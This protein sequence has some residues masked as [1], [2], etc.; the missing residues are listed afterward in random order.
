MLGSFSGPRTPSSSRRVSLPSAFCSMPAKTLTQLGITHIPRCDSHREVCYGGRSLSTDEHVI[1]RAYGEPH[2]HHLEHF[3]EIHDLGRFGDFKYK[4]WI[5]IFEGFLKQIGPECRAIL[6]SSFPIRF[7]VGRV[8]LQ[9]SARTLKPLWE[10]FDSIPSLFDPEAK[11]KCVAGIEICWA[12]ER[13]STFG[14]HPIDL[15]LPLSSQ[16]MRTIANTTIDSRRK[17]L[18]AHRLAR[19]ISLEEYGHSSHYLHKARLVVPPVLPEFIASL[20]LWEA[21]KTQRPKPKRGARRSARLI[22]QA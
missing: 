10:E 19:L 13:S 3:R 17:Q 14:S 21:E 8:H 6:T 11:V 22:E 20:Q 16:E 12:E 9:I 5:E 1:H 7:A 4:T 2:H 15:P 18:A